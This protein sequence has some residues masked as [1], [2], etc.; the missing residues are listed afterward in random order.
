MNSELVI[1]FSSAIFWLGILV[2]LLGILMILIPA[3]I[4]LFGQKMNV[5]V[6]TESAFDKAE[7]PHYLERF[8]YRYH[9]VIGL[10]VIAGA[11]FCLYTFLVGQELQV[12]MS[13]MPALN[14]NQVVSEWLYESIYYFLILAN[15]VCFVLGIFILARPST[16][17]GVE[18]IS[19]KWISNKAIADRLNSKQEIPEHVLPG[20]MRLF[21]IFVVVGGMYMVVTMAKII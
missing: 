12:L 3:K 17:K 2:V 8:F 16:L 4:H 11:G 21:G 20:N 6:S 10:F 13:K 1:W 15:A 5:W 19:N 7:Q 14:A 9:H 18:A